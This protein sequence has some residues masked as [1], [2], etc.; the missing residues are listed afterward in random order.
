MKPFTW[1]KDICKNLLT[2]VSC[3]NKTN[4]NKRAIRKKDITIP[5]CEITFLQMVFLY[6]FIFERVKLKKYIRIC[7]CI[8]SF[9]ESPYLY[10][11]LSI[12]PPEEG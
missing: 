1:T 2:E 4:D 12:L 6:T 8:H 10:H 5:T 7:I 9:T 3:R 11:C